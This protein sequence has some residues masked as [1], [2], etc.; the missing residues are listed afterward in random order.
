MASRFPQKRTGKKQEFSDYKDIDQKLLSKIP[1]S[2]VSFWESSDQTDS[3]REQLKE[4]DEQVARL[5]D[6][7]KSER[8]K[9]SRLQ[10]RINQYEAELKRREKQSNRM[11]ERFT[12]LSDKIKER[13]PTIEVLNFPPGGRGKNAT[14]FKSFRSTAKQE[15]A[16]LRLMLERREAELREA[17]KLRHS[18]TTLLHAIRIDMEETLSNSEGVLG[19]SPNTEQRFT[20]TEDMLGNHV[21]GGVVKSWKRVQQKLDELGSQ[22]HIGDGTDHDKLL[23]QLETEL[24]ESQQI[25]KLQQQILQDSLVSPIPSELADSYFLEEWERLQ[26]HWADLQNK[27]RTFEMERKSFTDAAIRLSHERRDFENQKGSLLKDQFLQDSQSYTDR[28]ASYNTD[29]TLLS[30][31]S[32]NISGCVSTESS[33]ETVSGCHLGKEQNISPSTPELYA[34]LRLPYNNCK[35]K[36]GTNW[37]G[38]LERGTYRGDT[39]P[40]KSLNW[41]F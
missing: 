25:V 30:P 12:Q 39:S 17:M 14:S 9:N 19:R 37:S 13:G 11:K 41:S 21:T 36:E 27:K 34:T 23:A 2:T 26:M 16:A 35:T 8:A 15:E 18:L 10:L 31:G 5:H 3:L 28:A 6:M 32:S 33:P 38:K 22:E 29:C 7:L 1:T 24:K 40:A 20:E 4:M